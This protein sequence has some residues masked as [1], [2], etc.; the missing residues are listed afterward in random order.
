[1]FQTFDAPATSGVLAP[2]IEA[3]RA[4]LQKRRL[5]AFLIPRADEHQNEYVPACAQRLAF[6]SGFTGSAGLAV[7]AIKSAA[8][9]V[10]GRYTVQ[11]PAETDISIFD[12]KGIRTTDLKP[13][14]ITALK[15][16]SRIGFD[17]RLHTITEIENLKSSLA[18]SE[19]TL[20]TVSSNPIDS[21]WAKERPAA[22]NAVVI[23]QSDERAGQSSKDKLALLQKVLR[24]AK[25]DA[26]VLSATDSICWLFNIRGSDIPH[27]PVVLANAIVPVSGKAD[28]FIAPVKVTREVRKHI[29]PSARLQD[30]KDFRAALLALK[31]EEKKVRLAPSAASWWLYRNLGGAKSVV[32]G[33]DPCVDL[34][35]VKNAAEIAGA[36]VAHIR[37]GLAVV[38]FLAWLDEALVEGPVDEITAV[39]KLEH[40]RSETG[41]LREIAFPTISGSGPNGAIVHYRV[42]DITN[43]VLQ[44]GELFLVDSG[45]Q[46]V[47]GT[48]DITRTIA[49]GTATIEMRERFTLVLKGMIAISTARFPKGTRGVD[50]DPYARRALWA[51]GLNYDHGTGHGVGSYLN[52][53]EGP[54]SISKNGQAELKPGM[55]LSNEP[56]YYKPGAYGIRIENLV[57]VTDAEAVGGD[58]PMMG[59]ET[60]TLAPI[61]RR[62]IVP[63]IL[64][65]EERDWVDMYHQRVRALLSSDLDVKSRRWLMA[66]T[67]SLEA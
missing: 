42:S 30:P 5:Q 27:N 36:K 50:L 65:A 4:Q 60:L 37:D 43:R 2:R 3:L 48:T 51:K 9:F 62:L 22:P 46:Y 8:L 39:K 23:V 56:G 45:G 52:V 24:D 29:A 11:A 28:L 38:R 19:L 1:M 54:A 67:A 21:V 47:D 14:L 66:A 17:P 15:R 41:A 35:A 20:V 32:R 10:D 7:I 18:G 44:K 16:G 53:H 31:A 33:A 64:S 34:K 57:L 6:I 25:H 40:H 59:F 61:D 55:I 58:I 49:V 13:W 63:T 12:V 26:M